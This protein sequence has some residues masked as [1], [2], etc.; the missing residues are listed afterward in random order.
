M[1]LNWFRSMDEEVFESDFR[2]TWVPKKK[3]THTDYGWYWCWW[4]DGNF[5][6]SHFNVHAQANTQTLGRYLLNILGSKEKSIYFIQYI[7][8]Q[9]NQR[10]TKITFITR[11]YQN[12]SIACVCVC[13]CVIW[14]DR[15]QIIVFGYVFFPSMPYRK[16]LILVTP[17]SH[18]SFVC[19]F[20]F[21]VLNDIS[22]TWFRL[23]EFLAGIDTPPEMRWCSRSANGY[24]KPFSSEAKKKKNNETSM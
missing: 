4:I 6:C 19:V 3:R 7:S 18:H 20:F 22:I 1:R 14:A 23:N 2:A 12:E 16:L 5:S 24:K 11:K 10:V 17:I 9:S 21:V 13:V 15:S 8:L